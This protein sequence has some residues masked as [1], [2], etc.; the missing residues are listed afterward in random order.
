ML[1]LPKS[2]VAPT[3]NIHPGGHK[4]TRSQSQSLFF[5]AL[6]HKPEGVSADVCQTASENETN[7]NPVLKPGHVIIDY[8]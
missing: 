3:S 1:N 6:S 7:K 8:A 5:F 4:R 2:R